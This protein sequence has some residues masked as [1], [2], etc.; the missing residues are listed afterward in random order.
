MIRPMRILH[1]EQDANFAQLVEGSVLQCAQG[2]LEFAR[3]SS[4]DAAL[5]LLVDAEYDVVLLEPASSSCDSI[6]SIQEICERAGR[7]PVVVLS[8]NADESLALTSIESGLQDYLV[9]GQVDGEGILRAVRFAIERSC[10]DS[11]TGQAQ[12]VAQNGPVQILL[13][14]DNPS[15]ALLIQANLQRGFDNACEVTIVDRL[16]QALH[17]LSRG[18]FSAVVL[19]LSLPDSRG[20]ETCVALRLQ[21]PHIPFVVHTGS[22]DPVL[23]LKTIQQGASDYLVKGRAG[24]GEL[25]RSVQYAIHRRHGLSTIRS[26]PLS[27]LGPT[28]SSID[29]TSSR[30]STMPAAVSSEEFTA[31]RPES[32]ATDYERR[33]FNRYP[34]IRSALVIPIGLGGRPDWDRRLPAIAAE[35]SRTG[36]FLEV[37]DTQITLQDCIVGVERRDGVLCYAGL[38]LQNSTALSPHRV[39]IGG[40]FGGRGQE[41]L[42]PASL[43]PRFDPVSM[44]MTHAVSIDILAA[45]CKIEVLRR[46]LLDR[47]QLCPRCT[48]VATFRSGCRSCGSGRVSEERLIH[49][50][51]CA[52]VG[53][54]ASFEQDKS[55]ACPKCR[56]RQLIVGA[57]FEYQS[58]VV[59]CQDCHWSGAD[60]EQVGQCLRCNFRFPSSNALIQDLTAYHVHRLDP[61]ALISA[62]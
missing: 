18:E 40:P 59:R 4:V 5:R 13:V 43:M 32:L 25:A 62:S 12:F 60:A 57:D 26:A 23:A 37:D 53:P 55:L 17:L 51:S 7:I 28:S 58:G 34:I 44:Q 56:T 11:V 54:V 6:R 39:R 20:V 49:H 50:F 47:I 33:S 2:D 27:L 16:D 45:W 38:E 14:E 41:I 36:L 24:R 9:K 21:T 1:V 30:L 22:N 19:D 10:Q 61:L 48:A 3:A 35:L 31:P 52:H 15:D 46:T 29:G 42:A 8:A